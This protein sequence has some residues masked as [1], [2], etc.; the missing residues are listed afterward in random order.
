MAV[1]AIEGLKMAAFIIMVVMTAINEGLNGMIALIIRVLCCSAVNGY[2][3]I[4][5]R[6]RRYEE[7]HGSGS[8]GPYEMNPTSPMLESK[9]TC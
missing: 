3:H 7:K 5:N 2:R 8:Q 6:R 9:E 4:R 1:L